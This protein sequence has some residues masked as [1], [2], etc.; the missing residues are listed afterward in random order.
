[1]AIR[2]VSFLSVHYQHMRSVYRAIRTRSQV[3]ILM[4]TNCVTSAWNGMKIPLDGVVHQYLLSC[5]C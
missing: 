2:G 5:W 4:Y 1:M 3:K